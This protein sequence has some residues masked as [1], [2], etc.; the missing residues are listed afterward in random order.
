MSKNRN[1]I[2]S[3]VLSKVDRTKV[4]GVYENIFN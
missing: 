4:D 1:K 2:V 3:F